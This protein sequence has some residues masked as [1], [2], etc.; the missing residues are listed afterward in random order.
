MMSV[1]TEEVPETT[2]ESS[3]GGCRSDISS[4]NFYLPIPSIKGIDIYAAFLSDQNFQ[5]N[6]Y[7]GY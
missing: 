7:H 1:L 3:V 2:G 5:V 4:G 6:L